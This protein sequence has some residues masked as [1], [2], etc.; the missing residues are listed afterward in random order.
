MHL[1]MVEKIGRSVVG[2]DAVLSLRKAVSIACFGCVTKIPSLLFDTH[3]LAAGAAGD[4]FG[5]GDGQQFSD[6][7]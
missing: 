4:G 2:A 5:Q 7:R 6:C 1:L 3:G